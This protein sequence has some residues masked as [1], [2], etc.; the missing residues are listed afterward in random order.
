MTRN[1]LPRDANVVCSDLEDPIP[2]DQS[3]TQS[4]R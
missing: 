4:A 3:G 2:S 1:L